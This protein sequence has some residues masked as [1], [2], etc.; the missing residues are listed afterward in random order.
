MKPRSLEALLSSLAQ[1]TEEPH[2]TKL[3]AD[4]QAIRLLELAQEYAKPQAP[5]QPNELITWKPG[6]EYSRFPRPGCAA[7][8]VRHLTDEE[9]ARVKELKTELCS[10]LF[11]V[12]EDILIGIVDPEDSGW[13]M[14][15]AASQFFQPYKLDIETH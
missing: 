11:M 8:V 10:P 5:F 6:F 14:F 9:K 7:I 2:L 4:A 12:E 15:T 3:Q 13:I 1:D